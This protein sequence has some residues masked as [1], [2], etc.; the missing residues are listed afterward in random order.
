MEALLLAE[1]EYE[2]KK[3][4]KRLDEAQI[5][6]AMEEGV[7]SDWGGGLDEMLRTRETK[8]VP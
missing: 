5:Q 1:K 2:I 6:E 8:V 3:V 7:G 4:T